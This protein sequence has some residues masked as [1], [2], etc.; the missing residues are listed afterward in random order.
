MSSPLSR[1]RLLA[2][3]PAVALPFGLG[4]AADAPIA[5]IDTHTH[6]YD[7]ARPEGVPWPAKTDALL[8]RTVLP[9]EWEALVAPH[10]VIGTVVVEASPWVEDNQWLLDLADRHAPLP[11]M[12]GIVGVVGNLPLGD[13]ACRGLIDRF[14]GHRSFRGIRV[15]GDALLAGLGDATFSADLAHLAATGLTLDV[16][17]GQ[18][19]AAVA[20]AA[21]RLPDLRI[22]VDHLGG[23][24]ITVEG[25]TA[26]WSEAIDRV[27]AA[28]PNVF[29]KVSALQE[30]AAHARGSRPGPTDT[31]FYAPWLE[32]VWKG[33]GGERLLYG[34][35]W[36]VSNLGGTYAD[37]LRIVRPFIAAR[38][39]AAEQ[40]FFAANA[41][42]A[43]QA[44]DKQPAA[45]HG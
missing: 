44:V 12:R 17:H 2:L 33:F 15:N 22:V 27:G 30:A 6:F 19:L 16:N 25:P 4:A 14:T 5:I 1:R 37:V 39:P 10:G 40:A 28:G 34:S 32:A 26:G 31:A 45:P 7:P 36:P 11:G 38:G 43:Y 18:S 8:H 42:R 3:G 23:P 35:N 29:M 13:R 21:R 41:L 9:P 20:A 24:R